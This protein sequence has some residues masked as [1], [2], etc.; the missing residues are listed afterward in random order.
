MKKIVIVLMLI[1]LPLSV[2]VTVHQVFLNEQVQAD[3]DALVLRQKVLFERNKRMLANI[4]IL[5]SPGRIDEL[6][7]NKLKLKSLPGNRIIHVEVLPPKEARN[8]GN[9]F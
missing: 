5:K 2:F 8:E 3:I 6:A 7:E 1:T 4:A 9:S